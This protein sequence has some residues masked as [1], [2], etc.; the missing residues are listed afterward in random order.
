MYVFPVTLCNVL[1]YVMLLRSSFL[2]LEFCLY[3]HISQSKFHNR[4]VT[5]I[6]V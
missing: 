2:L 1:L 5:S 4:V 6:A 3:F